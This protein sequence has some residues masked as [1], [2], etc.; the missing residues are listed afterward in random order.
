VDDIEINREIIIAMLDGSGIEIDT[1]VNGKEA[2]DAFCASEPYHYSLI[3]MDMQMPIMD[4]CAAT[5][6]IRGSG[7]SDAGDI[8]IIAM[9]ANV[10]PED[11][12]RA[13]R[14]GMDG[15]LTKPIEMNALYARLEE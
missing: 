1:A 12:E 13:S 9:T 4:G 8:R 10:L 2:M 5:E 7:R 14:S 11:M 6:E 15:Y 3:L